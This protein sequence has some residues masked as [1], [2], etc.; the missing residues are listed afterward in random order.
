MNCHTHLNSP[1][2]ELHLSPASRVHQDRDQL[3]V[4][5][6]KDAMRTDGNREETLLLVACF[7]DQLKHKDGIKYS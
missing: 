5:R 2:D 7:K 4:P 6:S 3:W 1:N